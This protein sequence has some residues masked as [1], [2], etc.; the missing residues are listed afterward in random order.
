[1]QDGNEKIKQGKNRPLKYHRLTSSGLLKAEKLGICVPLVV[2]LW[3]ISRIAIGN[4]A[5]GNGSFRRT[6]IGVE[7]MTTLIHGNIA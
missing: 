5:F 1:M 4:I 6:K 7:A 2:S 3:T